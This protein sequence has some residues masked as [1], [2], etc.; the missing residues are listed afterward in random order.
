MSTCTENIVYDE[1]YYYIQERLLCV[2]NNG[3]NCLL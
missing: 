3:T 2:K 1:R